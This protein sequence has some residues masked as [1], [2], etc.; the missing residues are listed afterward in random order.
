ME[1]KLQKFL[2]VLLF[3]SA[4]ILAA[5]AVD[6]QSLWLDEFGTWKLCSVTSFDKWVPTFLH[7]H[8]SDTQI[9]L[10]HFY[11][12]L[13][14][15]IVPLTEYGLRIANLPWFIMGLYAILSALP[16]NRRF[17]I[18]VTLA[19]GLHP[20]IWYYMNEARPYMVIFCGAALASSWFLYILRNDQRYIRQSDNQIWRLVIGLFILMSTSL[21]G[22]I[23]SVTFFILAIVVLMQRIDILKNFAMSDSLLLIAASALLMPV[24]VHYGVTVI[25][26][27]GATALYENTLMSFGFGFYELFGLVGLGPGRIELRDFGIVKLGEYQFVL[28]IAITFFIG[29]LWVGLAGAYRVNARFLKWALLSFILPVIILYILGDV[30]HWRIVGRH[31]YPLIIPISLLFAFGFEILIV[32]YST[33]Q[34]VLRISYLVFGI[35]VVCCFTYSTYMISTSPIHKRENYLVAAEIATNEINSGAS[36]WWVA[37]KFGAQYY[38]VPFSDKVVCKVCNYDFVLLAN[39]EASE[40]N[41]LKQPGLIVYSRQDTYDSNHAISKFI[42]AEHYVLAQSLMGFN[43]WKKP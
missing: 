10:Y 27:V 24:F 8:N 28:S 37:E 23:W 12:F 26:G 30:K 5:F 1:I 9:P 6:G 41:G 42:E 40:L 36:V 33:S 35:V 32:K 15:R 17:L 3:C 43:I 16:N 14:A 18:I 4:L 39:P 11:M 20:M 29:L 21:L 22:V 31:L 2:L 38:K 7:W 25:N 34:A 13:W 19:F